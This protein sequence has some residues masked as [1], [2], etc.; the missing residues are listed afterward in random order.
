MHELDFDFNDIRESTMLT[1]KRRGDY[2]QNTGSCGYARLTRWGHSAPRT[3]SALTEYRE[4][5]PILPFRRSYGT[6]HVVTMI[7]DCVG[8]GM[9][10]TKSIVD[11]RM[12]SLSSVLDMQSL[13]TSGLNLR[14][15][16]LGMGIIGF[17]ARIVRC[18]YRRF[19]SDVDVVSSR[20][21]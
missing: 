12:S 3:G 6:K 14:R 18:H 10:R 17:F 11:S 16:V 13:S 1:A 4:H 21:A 9:G 19:F 5:M 2:E 20:H 8:C 15:R 7:V